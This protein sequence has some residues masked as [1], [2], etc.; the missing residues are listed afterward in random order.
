MEFYT[1]REIIN[2]FKD[3]IKT[4][5]THVNRYTGLSYAQDP[6]IF[7]YETGN[8]L[9]GPIFGDMNVPVEWTNEIA[10]CIKELAP[11][12]LVVDGTYGINKTHL[13]IAT[14]DIFS[15]HFYPMNNTKLT[16]D[17]ALVGSV[18]RVYFAAEYAWTEADPRG[19]SLES[20][21]GVISSQQSKSK[22]VV[23]GGE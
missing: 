18:D 2:D 17:I 19:D 16:N 4:L 3:Y 9:G 23:A 1:N 21:L 12:K 15:D 5:L 6:T 7:A 8:E 14:I 11:L 22:P 20:F 10:S 13:N